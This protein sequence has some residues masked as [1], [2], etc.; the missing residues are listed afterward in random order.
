MIRQRI[1]A[2][3]DGAEKG[4]KKGKAG[5]GEQKENET[6][7]SI[8]KVPLDRLHL[9]VGFV[10]RITLGDMTEEGP[11]YPW[12][13]AAV[14]CG[15]QSFDTVDK[16]PD[17]LYE[18]FWLRA[19]DLYSKAVGGTGWS[20]GSNVTAQRI[21]PYKN[22]TF[23]LLGVPPAHPGRAKGSGQIKW[24][25]TQTTDTKNRKIFTPLRAHPA[26]AQERTKSLLA[27]A[28]A[29]KVQTLQSGG[30]LPRDLDEGEGA[31]MEF[32]TF[33]FLR[34]PSLLELSTLCSAVALAPALRPVFASDRK[35]A[36]EVFVGEAAAET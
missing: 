2:L 22:L 9:L 32:F 35:D 20:K 7:A 26:L 16:T 19:G 11:S 27:P 24:E 36:A 3:E 18:R 15:L 28:D 6:D 14:I 8:D 23:D 29:Q 34:N 33:V 5:D 30:R 13:W 21:S 25:V 31:P 1:K 4:R 10:N 12:Y 17:K